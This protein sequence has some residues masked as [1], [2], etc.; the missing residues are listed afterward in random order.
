MP[1]MRPLSR[2]GLPLQLLQQRGQPAQILLNQ[3]SIKSTRL[4]PPHGVCL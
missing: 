1:V 3:S 2:I 4:Q